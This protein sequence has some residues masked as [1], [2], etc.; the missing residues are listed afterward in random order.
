MARKKGGG[1]ITTG[2]AG[3]GALKWEGPYV[4]RKQRTVPGLVI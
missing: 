3:G 1:H 4:V 2:G